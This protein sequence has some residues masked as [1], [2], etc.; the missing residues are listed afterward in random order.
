MKIRKTRIKKAV[1]ILK[2]SLLIGKNNPIGKLHGAS[3]TTTPAI[4]FAK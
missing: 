3:I 4:F 1:V 2:L